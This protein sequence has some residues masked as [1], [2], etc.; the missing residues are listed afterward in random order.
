MNW[1]HL[2]YFKVIAE[3]QNFSRAAEQLYVTPSTLSKAIHCLEEEL[4]FPLFKKSGRNSVLTDYGHTFKTYVDQAIGCIEAGLND[5]QE[6]MNVFTGKISLAGIYTMC[7]E[8]LPVQIKSFLDLYPEVTFSMAYQITSIVLESILSG[9][10]DLGFCG[11][12]E[13]DDLQYSDIEHALIKTEELIIITPPNHPLAKENFVDFSKMANERF[14]IYRN[15]NSGLS[16]LFWSQCKQAGITPHVVF[17]AP[18]DHTVI[19]LVAVGLGISLIADSPSLNT[20]K[21]HVL[22]FAQDPPPFRNQYIVWKKDRFNPP[23]VRAFRD[24]ILKQLPFSETNGIGLSN[25]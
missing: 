5:I 21:V 18:D 13:L 24:F 16:K 25:P 17:E 14:I 8:Y 22:R 2:I 20:D 4:K 10:A 19:G 11:D 3:T 23:V 1:Q 12:F 7:A 9:T 15:V 6:Q